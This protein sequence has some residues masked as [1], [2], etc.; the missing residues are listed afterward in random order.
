MAAIAEGFTPEFSIG[1]H[2]TRDGRVA[3]IERLDP[4][5]VNGLSYPFFVGTIADEPGKVTWWHDGHRFANR[6]SV[7]DLVK[8]AK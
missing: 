1:T 4:G 2:R 3:T 6:T 7:D 5:I 8:P